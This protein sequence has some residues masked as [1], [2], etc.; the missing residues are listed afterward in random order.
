MRRRIRAYF[1]GAASASS[2]RRLRFHTVCSAGCLEFGHFSLNSRRYRRHKLPVGTRFGCR[3][4]GWRARA[5]TRFGG[6]GRSIRTGRGASGRGASGPS[7][8]PSRGRGAMRPDASRTWPRARCFVKL[9]ARGLLTLPASRTRN[10]HRAQA[11]RPLRLVQPELLPAAAAAAPAAIGG[12]LRAWPP[13]ALE[14]IATADP[15]PLPHWRSRPKRP[16]CQ[17]LSNR[18]RKQLPKQPTRFATATAPPTVENLVIPA[19]A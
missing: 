11:S 9:L 14:R 6:S 2:P 8:S 12:P 17:D 4:G 16:S 19:A 5:S 1:A 18:L 10:G 15:L 7:A 13:L 3:A